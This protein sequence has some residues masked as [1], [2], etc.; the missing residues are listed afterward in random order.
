MGAGKY[1]IDK[2][3]VLLQADLGG[4]GGGVFKYWFRFWPQV[5]FSNVMEVAQFFT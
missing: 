3:A 4:G 1:V 5:L 2:Y